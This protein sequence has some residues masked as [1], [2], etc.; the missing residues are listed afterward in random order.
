MLFS[1]RTVSRYRL[2]LV[3]KRHLH[4]LESTSLD[5]FLPTGDHS[6]ERT[7]GF[8]GN[9]SGVPY[10]QGYVTNTGSVGPSKA[11][12]SPNIRPSCLVPTLFT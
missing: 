9:R 10:C 12:V 1:P 6:D 2:F 3:V 8:R 4:T 7:G 5:C 11:S